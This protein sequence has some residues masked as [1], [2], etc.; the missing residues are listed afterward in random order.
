ML[1]LLVPFWGLLGFIL[2]DFKLLERFVESGDGGLEI[3]E[4]EL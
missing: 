1:Q 3:G 2:L 4:F